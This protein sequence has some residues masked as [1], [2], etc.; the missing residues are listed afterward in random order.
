MVY[1]APLWGFFVY[2]LGEICKK[3][4]KLKLS[5][6]EFQYRFPVWADV[7]TKDSLA[8]AAAMTLSV[9]LTCFRRL[10]YRIGFNAITWT[11]S[12]FAAPFSM[13]PSISC[14][15]EST[16]IHTQLSISLIYFLF[17]LKTVNCQED[18]DLIFLSHSKDSLFLRLGKKCELGYDK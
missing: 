1:P 2:K 17:A 15:F 16:H 14:Y 9:V 4:M 10:Q 5:L 6:G 7:S 13:L 11:A 18:N 3:K 12:E 8:A